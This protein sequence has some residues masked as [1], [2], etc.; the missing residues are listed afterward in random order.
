[1]LCVE[2]SGNESKCSVSGQ[3]ALLGGGGGGGWTIMGHTPSGCGCGRWEDLEE[4]FPPSR[5]IRMR[6]V[7]IE[8][9]R[10]GSKPNGSVWN[11]S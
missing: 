9:L 10:P 5:V 1:M 4:L 2:W 3:D 7:L 6:M 11:V 8:P